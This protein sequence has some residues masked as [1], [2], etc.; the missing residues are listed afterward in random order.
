M[1]TG[2]AHSRV[3]AT[4]RHGTDQRPSGPMCAAPA[5]ASGSTRRMATWLRVPCAKP[6]TTAR[7]QTAT[8][9]DARTLMLLD[10]SA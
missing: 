8:D 10:H 2:S 3:H 6:V 4:V 5:T 1:P 9:R 7:P